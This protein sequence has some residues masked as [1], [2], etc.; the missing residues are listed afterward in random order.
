MDTQ[1]QLIFYQAGCRSC[2]NVRLRS[3]SPPCW[4]HRP[5][6]S[7]FPGLELGFSHWGR[8]DS[9]ARFGNRD[10]GSPVGIFLHKLH[11]GNI[12]FKP[13]NEKWVDFLERVDLDI[14]C[15]AY[16]ADVRLVALVH[17]G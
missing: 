8:T 4:C 7:P 6:T 2:R 3:R 1:Q 17:N 14:F 15:A 10:F 12:L 13:E 16:G 5:C 9:V 11:R